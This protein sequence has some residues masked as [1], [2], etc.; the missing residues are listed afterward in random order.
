QE[1]IRQREQLERTEKRLDDI[2]SILRFSQKHIQGIKSVFGGLRNWMGKKNEPLAT[3]STNFVPS[4]SHLNEIVKEVDTDINK[5][6]NS[7]HPGIFISGLRIRGL[8][9]QKETVG[10]P[11]PQIIDKNLDDMLGS[12]TRLK[13]LAQG[14]GEE[15][16]SHNDI[17]ENVMNKTEKLDDSI[18]RKNK[19]I[20]RLLK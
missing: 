11:C 10:D 15:I 9:E 12:V 18:A 3:T 2:G 7:N 17:I 20:R 14:L 1:L 4:E 8:Y 6:S 16:E 13:V 5:S 19:E